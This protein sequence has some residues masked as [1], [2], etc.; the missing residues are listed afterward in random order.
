VAGDDLGAEPAEPQRIAGDDPSQLCR[1]GAPAGAD[2]RHRNDRRA[3]SST[4][5]NAAVRQPEDEVVV[6]TAVNS[7]LIYRDRSAA[8]DLSDPA[9]GEARDSRTHE[10]M[11]WWRAR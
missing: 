1:A 9:S 5:T 8:F 6:A 3:V 10:V 7:L 11:R 2:R 4:V